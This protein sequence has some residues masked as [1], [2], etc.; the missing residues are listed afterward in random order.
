[1]SYDISLYKSE[2]LR[3]AIEQNLGDWT[4]A[5]PIPEADLAA[6]AARL[7]AKG[8]VKGFC[9][10]QLG[11]EY[12]H[13]NNAWGI[14]VGIFRGSV[15]F[16]VAYGS[17]ATNAVAAALSDARELAKLTKLALYDPQTGEIEE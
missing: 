13:P 10:L 1:M 7:L 2:F 14:Q 3:R 9:H 4:N 17:D 11:D 12:T 15:G 6:I 5:D 16:T 8:Y